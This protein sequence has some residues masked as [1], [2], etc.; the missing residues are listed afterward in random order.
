MTSRDEKLRAGKFA[1]DAALVRGLIE[2]QFPQWAGL[3]IW[4][5][6]E[7]GWDNWTFHLGDR[8]KVRLPSAE[9]YAEQA[10]K[11]S[12]WLPRLAPH[13]PLEVPSPIGVGAPDETFPWPWSVYQWIEGAPVTREIDMTLMARHLAQFLKA[14]QAIPADGGPAPGQHSYLR[15]A[16]PMEAYGAEGRRYVEQLAGRIDVAAAQAVFDRAERARSRCSPVW[17]HGDV[18]AGNLLS[19]DGRLSAVLD[20]GSSAVGDP[21]CDLAIAYVLFDEPARRIFRDEIG[22]D[23]DTWARARAWTLWKAA[24]LALE[25]RMVHPAEHSPLAVIEAVI[26]EL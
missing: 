8:M 6:A 22:L 3:D 20:F 26:C 25:G 14:L 23:E 4:P 19:R 7:D 17:V 2:R 10:S 5:V 15:G 9:G 18:A 21:S 16:D 1:V 12:I 24:L 11:E 13:L